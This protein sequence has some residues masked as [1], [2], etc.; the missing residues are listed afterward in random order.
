V[1]LMCATALVIAERAHH[2]AIGMYV[3]AAVIV[4]WHLWRDRP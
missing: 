1:L 3:L 4:A 2:V